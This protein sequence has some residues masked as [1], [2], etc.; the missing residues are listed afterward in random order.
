MDGASDSLGSGVGL[1]LTN[2]NKVV[3][4]YVLCFLFKVM[5]NQSEYEALQAGLGVSR[6]LGVESLRIFNDSQLRS[7]ANS[8]LETP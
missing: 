5:N 6:E 2:S 1:I 4:E 3:A 8:K 7:L